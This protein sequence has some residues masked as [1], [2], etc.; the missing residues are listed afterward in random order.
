MNGRHEGNIH[1]LLTLAE[2]KEGEKKS[3]VS[4]VLAA[5]L[6]AFGTRKRVQILEIGS[7]EAMRSK[8]WLVLLQLNVRSN[9][10]PNRGLGI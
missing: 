6:R 5:G 1:S 4:G 3:G 7:S 9:L 2:G 10:L 8:G